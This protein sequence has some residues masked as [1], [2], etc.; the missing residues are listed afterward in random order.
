M[1]FIVSNRVLSDRFCRVD[2][3]ILS[4]CFYHF[5]FSGVLSEFESVCNGLVSASDSA[6]MINVVIF[7]AVA[8]N[9]GLQQNA[10]EGGL[11]TQ[12]HGKRSNA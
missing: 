2:P 10:S 3:L 5:E 6:A 1:I 8:T 12:D 4:V 7:S 9:Q 11:R